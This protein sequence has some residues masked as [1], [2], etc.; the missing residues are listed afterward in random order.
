V[1]SRNISCASARSPGRFTPSDSLPYDLL[2]PTQEA[3]LFFSD[4]VN[5][6]ET[7]DKL[8]SED[9]TNLLNRYLTEMTNIALEPKQ[10]PIEVKGFAEPVRC[11]KVL[12]LYDASAGTVIRE[13]TDGFK[14]L[15][16]LQK[17]DKTEIV[18]ALLGSRGSRPARLGG[19]PAGGKSSLAGS[20]RALSRKASFSEAGR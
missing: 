13:E 12:G 10:E 16:D 20:R 5:F 7:T 1:L 17:R 9:L 2:P 4:V 6:T 11:Y 18:A 8:E 3:D 15:L 14:L 19:Q